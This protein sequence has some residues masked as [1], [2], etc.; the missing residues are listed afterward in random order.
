MNPVLVDLLVIS[1]A[2]VLTL[3]VVMFP[4]YTLIVLGF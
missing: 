3:A 2:T 4:C 1:V